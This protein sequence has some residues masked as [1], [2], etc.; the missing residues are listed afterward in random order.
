MK[1][2]TIFSLTVLLMLS[3]IQSLM[4]QSSAKDKFFADY[5]A[6]VNKMQADNGEVLSPE[7]YKKAI[8]LFEEAN[9]AYEQ[10]ESTREIR[11]ML[12]EC[13]SYARKASEVIKMA[14]ITLASTIEARDAAIEAQAAL[15]ATQLWEEA[16][17]VFTRATENLEDNDVEDARDYG[18]EAEQLFR[19]AELLAIKN[20]I[21]GEARDAIAVARDLDAE[22]LA[23]HTFSDA[24]NLLAQTERLLDGNRYARE[25]AVEKAE[26]AAYQGRHAA[27]LAKTIKTLSEKEENWEKLMLKF[28]E[29]LSEIGSQFN[30]VPEFDQGFDSSV[31][32]IANYI[33]KLKEA[34]KQL[35]TENGRL[36]EE[37]SR[38]KEKEATSSAELQ[39]KLEREAAIRK[40]KSFFTPQ[41][42]RVIY[43]G[44]NI[45]IRLKGL[46]FPSGQY[47]IQPEYFSLLTK[48][49]KAL[50]VFPES[51]YTVEGHTDALGNAGKNKVLSDQRA[52]SVR[53]YLMANM[54][55]DENQITSIGYGEERPVASNETREGRIRNR[56]I[57]IVI[58]LNNE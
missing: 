4:A 37:L 48:V 28:E 21:L 1:T 9:K 55:L 46:T 20:G 17:E 32:S 45:T 22:E 44:D 3:G 14:H 30:Y 19:Q 40:I 27:Y 58:N 36:Q 41:E 42:A 29:I 8:E 43:E 10:K 51:H 39:K 18:L 23:Y 25:E 16:E 35:I 2:I 7:N 54:D 38:V 5:E 56:R 50:M 26:R 13:A 33:K 47:I 24:Q 34:K 11:E 12:E 49:Q 6:I 31:K 53:E 52:R 57:D 15:Y